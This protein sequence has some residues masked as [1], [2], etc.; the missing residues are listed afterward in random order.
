MFKGKDKSSLPLPDIAASFQE[1]VVDH[2]V[3]KTIQ[4]AARKGVSAI[5]VT[6]GV[7]MNSRLREVFSEA[8]QREGY[9]VLFTRPELCGDNAAMVAAAGAARLAYGDVAG[10]DLSAT[11]GVPLESVA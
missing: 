4:G 5:A 6:G 8:G 11:P 3:S 2:L 1:A 7:A 10:L 9:Q